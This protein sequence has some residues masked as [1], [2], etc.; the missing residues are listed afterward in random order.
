MFGVAVTS[1]SPAVAARCAYAR[2]GAGAIASQNVTDPTLGRRGLDLL[3]NG[4]SAEQ[5]IAILR[6]SD[7][8]IEH[9]Q[10]LAVDARGGAAVYSGPKALGMHAHATGSNV[11]SGGNLLASERLPEQIV[12]AFQCSEGDLGD[13]I[14]VAMRAGV[15]AGGEAGPIH[16]AGMK[17]VRD[18]PWPIADLRV[19]WTEVCPI[20]ELAGLW[21]RYRPQLEDYITRALDP[22]AAPSYGVPGDE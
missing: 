19:D 18:V 17:L 6:D 5:A 21:E 22:T 10:V 11:A 20:E 1:S 12:D 16:S 8:H 7:S 15:K 13:R 9:R 4:A 14:L 3:E 2:A